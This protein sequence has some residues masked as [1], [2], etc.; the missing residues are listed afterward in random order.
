MKFDLKQP[1]KTCPFR[2]SEPSSPGEQAMVWSGIFKADHSMTC[3]DTIIRDAAGNAIP[4]AKEQHCA[5]AMLVLEAQG[6]RNDAMQAAVASGDYRPEELQVT[7]DLRSATAASLAQGAGS[8][9]SISDDLDFPDVLGEF[10]R[11]MSAG[12]PFGSGSLALTRYIDNWHSARLARTAAPTVPKVKDHVLAA[13]VNNLRDI[14]IQFHAAGQLRERLRG[15]L[16][17]LLSGIES[18]S[19][20]TAAPSEMVLKPGVT[21]GSGW[22]V[23]CAFNFECA[24]GGCC[25]GCPYASLGTPAPAPSEGQ[26]I[27]TWPFVESPGDFAMRLNDAL[28]RFGGDTLSAVRNVLIE[29]PAALARPAVVS[30]GQAVA[31]DVGILAAVE[32]IEK[33]AADYI[34]ENASTENDTG[35]VV[36]HFGE[37]GRDYHSTLIELADDLRALQASCRP[38]APAPE[39]PSVIDMELALYRDAYGSKVPSE[40]TI[41]VLAERHRQI[42]MEGWTPKHDDEHANGDM[43]RAAATYAIT[44]SSDGRNF[45]DDGSTPSVIERLWPWDWAW[46]KPKGRRRNLVKAGA[47]ILA[48]IERI[49]RTTPATTGEAR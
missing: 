40:A 48:E 24:K 13:V 14:A 35:A 3:H 36:F 44:G 32:F 23:E 29:N 9:D 22:P 6:R 37:V 28:T 27:P 1:C 20:R 25:E 49:D 38:T 12:Q 10:F 19:A 41:D 39:A 31:P 7:A 5:G 33:R 47:L 8:I 15:A 34:Q 16:G 18:S 46:F 21:M 11:N 2:L 42:D 17:P 4:H 43:A 26:A 30:E 45:T